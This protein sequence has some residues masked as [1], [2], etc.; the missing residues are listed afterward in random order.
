MWTVGTWAAVTSVEAYN[1]NRSL[2]L[3][4]CLAVDGSKLISR[5]GAYGDAHMEVHYEVLV[6]DPVTMACEHTV[7]QP[8]GTEVRCLLLV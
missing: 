8:A 3:P 1:V 7:L 5:S 6:W 4:Y 2:Q